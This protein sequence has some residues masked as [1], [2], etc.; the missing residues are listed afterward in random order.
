MDVGAQP[1]VVGQVPAGIIGIVI[2][3]DIVTVPKPAITKGYIGRGNTEEETAKPEAIRSATFNPP[4]VPCTDLSG[5]M[6]VLPGMIQ[7]IAR[8]VSAFVPNPLVIV[9]V[10]VGRFRVSWLIVESAI[11]LRRLIVWPLLLRNLDWRIVSGA[12]GTVCR[13]VSAAN[14]RTLRP[15]LLPAAL[16]STF[17]FSSTT[18]LLRDHER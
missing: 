18:T 9:R 12:N 1:C 15:T 8:I 2:E 3:H 17:L 11:V 10:D 13:D 5:K 4:D 6:P 7:V 16:F 14:F